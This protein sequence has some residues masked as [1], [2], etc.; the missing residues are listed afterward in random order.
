APKNK[1]VETN[2][3]SEKIHQQPIIQTARL[4]FETD[5]N[6]SNIDDILQ[7]THATIVSE[8]TNNDEGKNSKEIVLNVPYNQFDRLIAK[9]ENTWGAPSYKTIE[10][11]GEEVVPEQLCKVKITVSGNKN[12]LQSMTSIEIPNHENKEEKGIA[13][14]WQKGW[15]GLYTVALWIIPFWPLILLLMIIGY[16]II[17]IKKK[18]LANDNLAQ[19]KNDSLEEN[20]TNQ[21]D[22]N[23]PTTNQNS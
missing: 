23:I 3:S 1:P 7:S 2:K 4:S 16:F 14:A 10:S 5:T 21:Q 11:T 18:K 17:R 13:G 19:K 20:T 15:T 9:L 6:I 22:P 12:N 8:I